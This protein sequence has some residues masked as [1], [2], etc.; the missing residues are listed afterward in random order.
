[1]PLPALP[2]LLFGA[3][4]FGGAVVAGSML[5]QTISAHYAPLLRPAERR[6]LYLANGTTP[7]ALPEWASLLGAYSAGTM[8]WC[9]LRDAA[10]KLG[11]R[12]PD[13][14]ANPG[15][16]LNEET[17]WRRVVEAN[18]PILDWGTARTLYH[19]DNDFFQHWQ[20][21]VRRS[22]MHRVGLSSWLA[23]P[24]EPVPPGMIQAAVALGRMDDDEASRQLRAH[25]YSNQSDRDLILQPPVAWTVQ[26][27]LE[28]LLRGWLTEAQADAAILSVVG[29]EPADRDRVK[30][31][32]WQVPGYSDLVRFWHKD[33]W[34]QDIVDAFGLDEEYLPG[35]PFVRAMRAQG[36]GRI[37]EAVNDWPA[38]LDLEWALAYHRAGWQPLSPTQ[39]YDFH[40]RFGDH[41]SRDW[42]AATYPDG[43]AIPRFTRDLLKLVLKQADYPARVR[44]WQVA[45]SFR[46]LGRIDTRRMYERDIITDE[47]LPELYMD[48]GYSPA[49][50]QRQARLAKETRRERDRARSLKR[51]RRIIREAFRAFDLGTVDRR[52]TLASVVGAGMVPSDAL[53]E[54]DGVELQRANDTAAYLIGCV[55]RRYLT[56]E[57]NVAGARSLLERGGINGDRAIEYTD[58]WRACWTPKRREL[59][60]ADIVHLVRSRVLSVAQGVQRLENLGFASI[61]AQLLMI[62]T[63]SDI[64]EDDQKVVK[65]ALLGRKRDA[66][67]LARSIRE[68]EAGLEKVRATLR[69]IAPVSKL[70]TWVSSRPAVISVGVFRAMMRAQGYPDDVAAAHLA[71]L[72]LEDRPVT[73]AVP[74]EEDN[75]E[76]AEGEAE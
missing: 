2:G 74:E 17:L 24:Q 38:E 7:N 51:N 22:G 63:Q 11:I 53:A 70:R 26:A 27:I 15:S 46:P 76:E 52:D 36:M 42:I 66:A 30:R 75:A 28:L 56:G 62:L 9:T 35:G 18:L 60:R 40:H 69:R 6:Q 50:A 58:R 39:A 73:V 12:L 68:R 71:E 1:M 21:Q 48:Q 19:R 33:I 34:R 31:T 23:S 49:H 65:A 57:V 47:E 29:G 10:K 64:L 14:E 54:L 45:A 41:R 43:A 61:D 4:K 32:R 8:E 59:A 16:L 20:R 55:R 3:L 67:D 44:D 25:G 5:S 37:S 13:D 72:R